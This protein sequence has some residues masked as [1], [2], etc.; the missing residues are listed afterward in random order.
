VVTNNGV[1]WRRFIEP[2]NVEQIN[3]T[4]KSNKIK[5]GVNDMMAK[6][7]VCLFCLLT[8]MHINIYVYGTKAKAL[9]GASDAIKYKSKYKF[10]IA[11]LK[12]VNMILPL[13]FAQLRTI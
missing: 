12:T 9:T 4:Y 2:E 10:Q 6:C 7:F 13:G 11:N 3:D 5:V 1:K 8:T